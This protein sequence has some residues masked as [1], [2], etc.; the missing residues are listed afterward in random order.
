MCVKQE[1]RRK[2]GKKE[3]LKAG[4][5][6]DERSTRPKLTSTDSTGGFM[7]SSPAGFWSR[8]LVFPQS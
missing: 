7:D 4:R 8:L 2:E 1:G 6:K 5:M 3:H